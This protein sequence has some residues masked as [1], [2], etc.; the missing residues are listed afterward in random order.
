MFTFP[1]LWDMTLHRRRAQRRAVLRSRGRGSSRPLDAHG[2]GTATGKERGAFAGAAVLAGEAS[3]CAI[4]N[5]TER[6]QSRC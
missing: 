3:A 5:D 2:V 4:F 1:I 6:E